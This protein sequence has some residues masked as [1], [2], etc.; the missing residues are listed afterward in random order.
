VTEREERRREHGCAGRRQTDGR[1]P[2]CRRFDRECFEPAPDRP[3]FP[4][5]CQWCGRPIGQAATGRPRLYCRQSCRQRAYERRRCDRAVRAVAWQR[6]EARWELEGLRAGLWELAEELEPFTYLCPTAT[7][8]DPMELAVAVVDLARPGWVRHR[9]GSYFAA[10]RFEATR[11]Q[12]TRRS[13]A[14]GAPP[15]R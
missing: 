6:D 4:T 5:A 10:K 8:P 1:R 11:R 9:F 12:I 3:R 7:P 15:R 13:L 14:R 2:D